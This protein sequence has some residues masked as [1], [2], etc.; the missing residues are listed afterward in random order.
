MYRNQPKIIVPVFTINYVIN[1]MAKKQTKQKNI[2]E[3]LW[4]SANKLWFLLE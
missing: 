1:I 2:E 4:E 3:T